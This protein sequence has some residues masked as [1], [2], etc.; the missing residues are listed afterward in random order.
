MTRKC[1]VCGRFQRGGKNYIAQQKK[2]RLGFENPKKNKREKMKS[3]V[4]KNPGKTLGI[5]G[6]ALSTLAALGLGLGGALAAEK[7]K[8]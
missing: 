4:R 6:A 1:S 7:K 5:G 8:K 3:F 2:K